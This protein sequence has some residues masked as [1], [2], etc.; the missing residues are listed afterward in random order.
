MK[1]AI[2]TGYGPPD[3][4]QLR[5]IAKPIPKDNE[6]LIKVHAATVTAGDCEIR[7]LKFP[8][9]LSIPI[10]LMLSSRKPE[11]RILGQELSGE[12]EAVGKDVTSF[13]KGDQIFAAAGLH[14]GGYAEYVC[15]P[16]AGVMAIKPANMTYDEATAV[17][18]G[19]IEALHFLRQATIQQGEQVLIYGSGGGIGT[20]SVQ[21]AKHFGATV[22]AV[23]STGKL[24]MLRSIGADHVIDYTQEDF[25]KNHNSYDVIL[26]VVGKSSF[27]KSIQALRENG[28]YLIANP[29]L[30]YMIQGLWLSRRSSKKVIIGPANQTIE[31]LIVLKELI[32]AG[33][34]KTVID[35]RYPLEQIVEAHRYVDSGQKAGNVVI[36][37]G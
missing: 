11:N 9:W 5:E 17:P 16:S 8:I 6:V 30:S 18:T 26:D 27:S 7:S 36:T 10:R 29:H 28:R 21:L 14:F 35:R 12:I 34:I 37:M 23:D 4:L 31:D 1:A 20:I 25:T 22:T 19:G 15:L 13:K 24:D 33:K 2:L 3:V 32:E